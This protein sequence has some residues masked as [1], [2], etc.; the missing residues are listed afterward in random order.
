MIIKGS[1]WPMV[2][3]FAYYWSIIEQILRMKRLLIAV[4]AFTSIAVSAQTAQSFTI[5]GE[6]KNIAEPIEK[7]YLTYRTESEVISDSAVPKNGIYTFKG[8]LVEPMLA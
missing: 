3:H 7:V 8:T 4:F 5:E 6:L 1:A 2:G